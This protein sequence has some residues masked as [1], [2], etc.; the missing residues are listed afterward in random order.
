MSARKWLSVML[1]VVGP[2]TLTTAQLQPQDDEYKGNW[3]YQLVKCYK[4]PYIGSEETVSL[5][6]SL[7]AGTEDISAR[8]NE[9]PE[10]SSYSITW[11]PEDNGGTA[12]V[13]GSSNTQYSIKGLKACTD[14][15]VTV[16]AINETDAGDSENANATTKAKDSLAV[17]N[18]TVV[19]DVNNMTVLLA[20]WTQ[21]SKPGNCDVYYKISWSDGINAKTDEV[22][23]I[24]NYTIVD[25]TPCTRYVV[26]V[27]T[28]TSENY[29]VWQYQNATMCSLN[30]SL[31][32]DL[33]EI[34]VSWSPFPNAT[35]YIIT[36][37]PEDNGGAA[38][39]GNVDSNYTISSLEMCTWYTVTVQAW[40]QDSHVLCS[41][42]DSIRT[43]EDLL[44]LSLSA[45]TE[46]ISARWNEVPEASSYS[47]TWT[48]EDNGG[49]A[50]VNG[51]SNS[52]YSIKGLKACTNYSVTVQAMKETGNVG[53][54]ETN[55]RITNIK[56]LLDLSLSAGT[57]SI[58]AHWNEVPDAS[59]YTITWTQ[60][61]NNGTDIVDVVNSTIYT[62]EGLMPCTVYRVTVQ[63]MNDARNV[64]CLDTVKSRTKTN[65]PESFR[66]ESI[67]TKKVTLSWSDANTEC[68][69]LGYQLSYGTT[70]VNV[71]ANTHQYTVTGLNAKKSYSFSLKTV[72]NSGES[73][74]VS[75]TISTKVDGVA[76]GVGV[77]V[78]VLVV[79]VAAVLGYIYRD[80]LRCSREG[81]KEFD[82]RT[83]LN[84][85]PIAASTS[86]GVENDYPYYKHK[87]GTVMV[88]KDMIC[89]NPD[90]D[91]EEEI[92]TKFD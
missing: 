19:N 81:S 82:H 18:L 30:L 44:Q 77:S 1:L 74:N 52:Q 3:R 12:T 86:R 59:F 69:A 84:L 51:S 70:V 46:D 72:T 80:K 20:S 33:D 68:Q 71:S 55:T 43:D 87:K 39:A 37:S 23:E 41:N 62:I 15:T 21:A 76:I 40:D 88:L 31:S 61:D 13:N 42:S 8:W 9:V 38:C 35:S 57:E 4:L 29:A 53:C 16:Q 66:A 45:G 14:Y 90:E 34:W 65:A 25:L 73:E 2:L 58:T 47:I 49:T 54:S 22:P 10:A 63:A 67:K 11:T 7:S 85:E 56:E 27:T 6:L 17:K 26:G 36:W 32:A 89:E 91:S 75:L 92:Y 79:V 83:H 78:G 48:P 50:T 24:S 5:N 28:R 60:V 64:G